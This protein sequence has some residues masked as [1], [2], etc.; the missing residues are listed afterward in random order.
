MQLTPEEIDTLKNT[1]SETEW[2]AACDAVKAA[3]GGQ[4]PADWFPRIIMSGLLTV[5][6][7]NWSK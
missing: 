3:R 7:R 5:T 6:Q 2:N 4:Y 1:K